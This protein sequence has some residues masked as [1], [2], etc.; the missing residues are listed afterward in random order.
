MAMSAPYPSIGRRHLLASTLV[1]TIGVLLPVTP[2]HASTLP[3]ASSGAEA[4]APA[5]PAAPASSATA[6]EASLIEAPAIAQPSGDGA[7]R[8]YKYRA[9]DEALADLK[10]RIKAT[11]WPE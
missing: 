10:R 3:P 1:G 5:A 7:I 9:S 4:L 6:I 11:N 2:A 8:P